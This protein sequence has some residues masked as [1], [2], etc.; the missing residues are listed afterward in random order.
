MVGS[1]FSVGV[2]CIGGALLSLILKRY[3]S[4]Q[5]LL[6]SIA[7]CTIVF[8]AAVIMLESP[9]NEVR[10]IFLSAGVSESI[11]AILFKALG[12][13]CITH[14]S[15]ELCRDSGEGAMGAAAELWGRTA[16]MVISLPIVKS[17][18]QLIE[19]LL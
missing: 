6:L 10:E 13:S 2:F 11:I 8:S 16:I 19:K 14:I 3:C 15:A 7:V 5:S 17:F 12:I 9:L 4:E 1:C 18:L